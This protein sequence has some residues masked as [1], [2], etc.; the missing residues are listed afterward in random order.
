MSLDDIFKNEWV[1]SEKSK[2]F[3]INEQ[4][5]PPFLGGELG[6]LLSFQ[7][8][9]SHVRKI[10]LRILFISICTI[11]IIIFTHIKFSRI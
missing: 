11:M 4:T 10:M 5:P 1:F 6:L 2:L 7:A 3:L 8:T 9:I